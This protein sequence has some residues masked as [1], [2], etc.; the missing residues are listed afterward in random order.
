MTKSL[1]ASIDYFQGPILSW[2]LLREFEPRADLFGSA[3]AKKRDSARDVLSFR[4]SDCSFSKGCPD[5]DPPLLLSSIRRHICSRRYRQPRPGLGPS[6][7]EAIRTFQLHSRKLFIHHLFFWPNN[8]RTLEPDWGANAEAEARSER[9]AA[10]LYIFFLLFFWVSTSKSSAKESGG[11]ATAIASLARRLLLPPA[12]APRAHVFLRLLRDQRL[13]QQNSGSYF[14]PSVA[15]KASK[16]PFDI[17]SRSRLLRG[18][19]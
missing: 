17:V 15:R 14:R 4:S 7:N 12:A 13:L 3:T 16:T 10:V 2:Q 6:S 5:T 9:A 18:F 8:K 11:A 19:L 1:N